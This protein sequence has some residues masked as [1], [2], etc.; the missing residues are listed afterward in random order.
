MDVATTCKWDVRLNRITMTMLILTHKPRIYN[1]SVQQ[2]LFLSFF[3]ACLNS[4]ILCFRLTFR[5]HFVLFER[6]RR[7]DNFIKD[8]KTWAHREHLFLSSD[9]IDQDNMLRTH[10]SK[11]LYYIHIKHGCVMISPYSLQMQYF[12]YK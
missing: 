8:A 11:S 6:R 5:L 1:T 2:L 9:Q 10:F 4:Y 3:I 12:Y 7:L